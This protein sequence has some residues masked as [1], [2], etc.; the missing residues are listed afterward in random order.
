M[1]VYIVY[2]I[3]VHNKIIVV[4]VSVDVHQVVVILDDG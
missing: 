2:C 3:K 4:C 1:N